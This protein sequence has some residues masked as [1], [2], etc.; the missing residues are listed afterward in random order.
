MNKREN[1]YFFLKITSLFGNRRDSDPARLTSVF[2]PGLKSGYCALSIIV[3]NNVF[4]TLNYPMKNCFFVLIIIN[5]FINCSMQAMSAFRSEICPQWTG[6]GF[7]TRKIESTFEI[8][9][10]CRPTWKPATIIHDP[11]N[12]CL[13]ALQMSTYITMLTSKCWL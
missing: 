11:W 10:G 7:F 1:K 4:C 12:I 2:H 3:A 5:L 6:W 13:I 8:S 9:F